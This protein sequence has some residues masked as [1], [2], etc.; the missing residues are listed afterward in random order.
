MRLKGFGNECGRR[1][2]TL[3]VHCSRDVRRVVQD[4]LPHNTHA[5]STTASARGAA[6]TAIAT[7]SVSI[8]TTVAPST[9]AT[10]TSTA[11][12]AFAAASFATT[13]LTCAFAAP[14]TAV[15]LRV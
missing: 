1:L 10:L 4:L 2:P 12:A 9:L 8:S 5:A 7:T 15:G 3:L 11:H 6:T 14:A 13:T